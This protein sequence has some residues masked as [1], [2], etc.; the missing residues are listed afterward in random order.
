MEVSRLKIVIFGAFHAGKSTF[1]QAVDPTSRH[2]DTECGD[3]TTTVALDYGKVVMDGLTVHLFGTPGQE[4]FEFARRIIMEGMDAALLLVDC[5]CAVD[6]FTKRLYCD[7]VDSHVPLGLMLNK[8]DVAES[9]PAMV[10]RELPGT[11]NMYEISARD[12]SSVREALGSFVA[13]VKENR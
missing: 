11:G 13:I 4:R 2:I 1:I 3:G 8:C 10:R 12:P 5:S 7:L 9:C 6:D